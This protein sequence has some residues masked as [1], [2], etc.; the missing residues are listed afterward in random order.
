MAETDGGSDQ[1]LLMFRG[2]N[3]WRLSLEPSANAMLQ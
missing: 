2:V 1:Y 3:T